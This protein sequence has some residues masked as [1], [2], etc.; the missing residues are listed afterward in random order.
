MR[1]LWVEFLS[2]FKNGIIT[3]LRFLFFRKSSA[4]SKILL[5]RTGSIGDNICAMPSIAAI[6]KTFPSAQL[7]ILTNAGGSNLVSLQHLLH[8]DYYNKIIDYLGYNGRQLFNVIRKEKYDLV[9]E[10][11]QDQARLSAQVRNMI[12]FRVAGIRSGVGWQVNTVFSFRQVQEKKM[13]F[14][15]ERER[16]LNLLAK[17]DIHGEALMFPLRSNADDI[18]VVDTFLERLPSKKIVALVPGAKRPQNR[19]PFERFLALASWLV[20]K[21]YAVLIIG[22]G[23]DVERGTEF[24]TV[25]GTFDATGKFSPAQSA[26]AL[27]RCFITISNDTGPM[28]LSYAVG[29]PVIGLFSSRDFQEKWFPPAGN[30]ALRNYN[31]H[32]SLCLS[33]TCRNNICMQGIPLDKVKDAFLQLEATIR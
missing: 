30:I 7:H 16:L 11:P 24:S 4:P 28:H 9:I 31:V 5:F 26:I 23:E 8:K 27:S 20:Q 18:R 25:G 12:F 3:V 6:R 1:L 33:E 19:Y 10:L 2:G 15:S 29:T 32:C 21:D 14:I 13:S 17:N 22:G